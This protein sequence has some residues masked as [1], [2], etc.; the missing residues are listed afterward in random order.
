MPIAWRV[1]RALDDPVRLKMLRAVLTSRNPMAVGDIC[2]CVG[3]KESVTSQYLRILN[4]QGF[5]VA[6]RRGRHVLYERRTDADR[7]LT[8]VIDELAALCAHGGPEWAEAVLASLPAFS[9]ARKIAILGTLRKVGGL[10]LDELAGRTCMPLKTCYRIVDELSLRGLV[11]WSDG[12]GVV[13]PTPPTEGF[14]K[15][16]YDLATA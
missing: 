16:F 5:I 1:C 6:T 10:K 13:T 3:E 4:S 8:R 2:S 9:S 12:D 15:A 7:A 11:E 14:A